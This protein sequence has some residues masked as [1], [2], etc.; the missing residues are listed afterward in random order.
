MNVPDWF[1]DQ[2]KNIGGLNPYGEPNLRVV[3]SPSERREYGILKGGWKYPQP[4]KPSL[5]MECWMLEVWLS[6]SFFGDPNEW[7]SELLGPF[8]TRGMYGL[9]SPLI[10]YESDG[11]AF[12]VD[13]DQGALNAIR[14]K[15]FADIQWGEMSAKDRLESIELALLRQ[16]EEAEARGDLEAENLMDHYVRNQHSIDQ[17]D[18][19]V[20]SMPSHLSTTVKNSKMPV[21]NL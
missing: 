20:W 18:K 2:L 13:L 4:D 10:A 12:A 19:R 1:K 9:K 21:R 5:P 15:Y 6:P 3:W 14:E 17:E 11:E 16:R 7:K 8:P